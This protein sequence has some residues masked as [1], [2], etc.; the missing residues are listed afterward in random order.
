MFV[1]PGPMFEHEKRIDYNKIV[2]KAQ[3]MLYKP[4]DSSSESSDDAYAFTMSSEQQ[5]R[6]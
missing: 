6:L 5:K 4:R 2:E 3:R 1:D